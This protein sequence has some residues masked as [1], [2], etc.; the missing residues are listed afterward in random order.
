MKGKSDVT[1][2]RVEELTAELSRKTE[3]VQLFKVIQIDTSSQKE[4]SCFFH[5]LIQIPRNVSPV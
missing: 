2:A 1:E 4:T 5:S 3:E